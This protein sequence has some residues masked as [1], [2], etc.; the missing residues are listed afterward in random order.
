[1][2]LEQRS[3]RR[4]ARRRVAAGPLLVV[5]QRFIRRYQCPDKRSIIR[6]CERPQSA[7]VYRI[8]SPESSYHIARSSKGDS[9]PERQAWVVVEGAEPRALPRLHCNTT[10]RR[11]LPTGRGRGEPHARLFTTARCADRPAALRKKIYWNQLNIDLSM[12]FISMKGWYVCP[13]EIFIKF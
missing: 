9:P 13:N 5:I 3:E 11:D 6:R 4:K 10:T 8:A 12:T 7:G 1:M 2:P